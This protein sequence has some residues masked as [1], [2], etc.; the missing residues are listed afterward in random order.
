LA[1]QLPTPAEPVAAQELR[2]DQPP[3]DGVPDARVSTVTPG[4]QRLL[5]RVG[6]WQHCAPAAA[7]FSDMQA[8]APANACEM[9]QHCV[10]YSSIQHRMKFSAA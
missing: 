3:V 5:D 8:R 4:S 7:A 1:Q 2:A 9:V 10:R 6:A